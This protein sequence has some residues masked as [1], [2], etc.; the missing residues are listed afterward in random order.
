MGPRAV[1]ALRLLEKPIVLFNVDDPTGARDGRRFD[2]LRKAIPL[3]DLCVVVRDVNVAEFTLRGARGRSRSGEATTRSLIAQTSPRSPSPPVLRGCH[4][5]RHLDATRSARHFAPFSQRPGLEIAVWGDRWDKSSLWLPTAALLAWASLVGSAT[6]FLQFR[7]QG[8]ASGFFPGAIAT[9]TPSALWKSLMPAGFSA[10]SAPLST[11]SSMLRGKRPSSGPSA[12]ECAD[13]C[14][15]LLADPERQERI[16]TRGNE[17]RSR[18]RGGQRGYLPTDSCG[19][20]QC[21]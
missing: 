10:P 9:Y 5:H 20:L 4:I 15:E 1:S 18:E 16:R 12:D 17:A 6:T 7:G 13:R 14:L 3:Y 2:S 8:Y 21:E 11:S 19:G